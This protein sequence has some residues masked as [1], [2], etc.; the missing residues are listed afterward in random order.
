MTTLLEGAA[1]STEKHEIAAVEVLLPIAH[2]H[3]DPFQPRLDCDAELADSIRS[4]GVLQAITVEPAQTLDAVCE[5]CGNAFAELSALG[6]YMINDG[7]RRWRGSIAAKQ[8]HILA[9]I[10]PPTEEGDRLTRQLTANT[11]KPLTPFEEAV[12]FQRLMEV[13]EWSQVQ[14][15][16][17]L[18][19]PRATIGDRLRLV[20][21][22]KVWLD[23]IQSGRLQI[24]HAP[25]IHQYREVPAEYQA[26]A[27]KTIVD[28]EGWQ[29]RRYKDGAD[30]VIPVADFRKIIRNAFSD[31][32]VKLEQVR[33]Y[34]GPVLEIEEEQYSYGSGTKLRKVKYAADIK[35]WRPIKREAE[36]R[37]KKQMAGSGYSSSSRAAAAPRKSPHE[38]DV[39]ALEQFVPAAVS[40]SGEPGKGET[41]VFSVSRGW[42]DELDPATLL[43]SLD[44]SSLRICKPKQ[45]WARPF[46][47]TTDKDAVEKARAAYIESVKEVARS[48]CSKTLSQL[49]EDVLR[50]HQLAGPGALELVRALEARRDG[51]EVVLAF[52]LSLEIA[53]SPG[54]FAGHT[55]YSVTRRADAEKL[56]SA[57]AAVSALK[58]HLPEFWSL[59]NRLA[60]KRDAVRFK[61]PETLS[62]KREKRDARARG[63]QVG[64]PSRAA[65]ATA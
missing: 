29:M 36:K 61:L 60:P 30:S 43:A 16:K 23:L 41:K 14:L 3:P 35:L 64:D 63:D 25:I 2:V 28:G 42:G 44:V 54:K 47:V 50:L 55:H 46:V 39:E 8:T 20:E 24:S 58:L 48:A 53:A 65:V 26:K 1:P 18:G 13:N 31:Y 40:S 4:Q 17:H 15:A 38:I 19:R 56:L 22:D 45:R 49:S 32:I 57:L 37:R 59:E 12:A 7:E 34:K 21:L 11:G 5:H 62:K 27:A 51:A 9:K 6:H 10:I 33:S 52:A